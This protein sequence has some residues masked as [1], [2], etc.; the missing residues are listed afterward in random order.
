MDLEEDII[1][2]VVELTVDY[3][4]SRYPDVAEGVPYEE[5]DEK[6]A[7]EKVKIAKRVFEYLK[8]KYERLLES[9]ND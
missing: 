6:T 9:E 2:A 5:Y 7:K 8:N 1:D 4:F 3:T